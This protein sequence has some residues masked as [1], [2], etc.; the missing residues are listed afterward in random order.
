V[1][2]VAT[3]FGELWNFKKKH[4]LIN[5]FFNI[6]YFV[7]CIAS[8]PQ[9]ALA[10]SAPMVIPVLLFGGFFLQNGSVPNYLNWISYLSW[11]MYGNE[12]LS[13]NQWYGVEFN[14]TDCQYVGYN[15]TKFT[16]F[17]P[18]NADGP[19]ANFIEV[20]TGIYAAYE[21]NVACSGND[22]LE[23]YNFNPV[24]MHLF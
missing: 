2:N 4:G 1:T 24:F 18:E 7:S 21:K 15:I 20:L 8:T 22:I 16:D 10:I 11:F 3:S 14:N 12:A 17:L 6:G 13:I 5:Y 23:N 19:I 9:V